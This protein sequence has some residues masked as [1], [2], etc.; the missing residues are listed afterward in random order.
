MIDLSETCVFHTIVPFMNLLKWGLIQIIDEILSSTKCVITMIVLV[1]EFSY[2]KY[3]RGCI[4]E[5]LVKEWRQYN[6]TI[7]FFKV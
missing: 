1:S 6:I 2:E 3:E 4:E 5:K 7:S